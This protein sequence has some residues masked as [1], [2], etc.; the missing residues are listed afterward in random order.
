MM[1]ADLTLLLPEIVLALM[2][3]LVL[4]VDVYLKPAWKGLTYLLSQTTLLI[5]FYCV[6]MTEVGASSTAFANQFIADPFSQTLKLMMLAVMFVVLLYSRTYVK[7][8]EMARGEF[9]TLALFSTLGMMLLVSAKSLLM[10][11]LGLELLSLPLYAMVALRRDSVGSSEAGMKYFI[12][13]ALASGMLLYGMS[14]IYGVTNSIDLQ[15][16]S[17]FIN[18]DQVEQMSLLLFGMIFI[19]IGIAFKLGAVP[20]HMWVPDVYEGAPTNVALLIAT[21]PKLAAFGMAYRLLNDSLMS[22]SVEWVHFFIVLAVLSL[23]LGN[24]VAIAQT[25]I[26]R[27]LAYS[28][29]AHVGFLLLAILAAPGQSFAPA[30]YYIVVYTIMAAMAFGVIILMGAKDIE[31]EQLEDLKGLSQRSPWVAFLMLLVMFSFAGVPPTVGFYAKFMVLKSLVDMNLIWLAALA[32]FFSIIGAFYYLRV[33]WFMYFE[34]PQEPAKAVTGAADMR[35][36]L[37][38]HG[39]SI[40]ALGIIPAPLFTICQQVFEIVTP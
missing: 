34:P 15:T 26:K 36:V 12:M 39:I 38:I 3:V 28:T 19:L 17:E 22:L 40:L 16:I 24:I 18:R 2:A 13:G 20:C 7:D 9:H 27:L 5:T 11:Y 10:I 8:R 31:I 37:S 29:I 25:N 33:V 32:V 21:A 1:Q 23:A 14:I 6:W 30:M 4:I 35:A